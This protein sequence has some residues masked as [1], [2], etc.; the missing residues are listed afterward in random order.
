MCICCSSSFPMQTVAT[1]STYNNESA[2]IE[3]YLD[4]NFSPSLCH[5]WIWMNHT[6]FCLTLITW[7]SWSHIFW[8]RA[9]I[10][11]RLAS[12]NLALLSK[13]G[14]RLCLSLPI[15]RVERNAKNEWKVS[16]FCSLY[17]FLSPMSEC[18]FDDARL[19]P[20]FC[21]APCLSRSLHTLCLGRIMRNYLLSQLLS[22]L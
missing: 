9:S 21:W 16:T 15:T 3:Q 20:Q 11:Q 19:V 4:A 22:Q 10:K 8:T 14:T 12:T 13:L 2:R 1:L 5:N 18:W 6:C 17:S 7:I